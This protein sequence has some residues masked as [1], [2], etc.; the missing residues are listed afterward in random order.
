MSRKMGTNPKDFSF[1]LPCCSLHLHVLGGGM[2]ESRPFWVRIKQ[3]CLL[4]ITMGKLSE[5][6]PFMSFLLLPS[7]TYLANIPS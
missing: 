5:F 4:E 3:K 7:E 6:P 2:D 1:A